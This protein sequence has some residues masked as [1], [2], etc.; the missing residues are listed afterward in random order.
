MMQTGIK[1]MDDNT[2]IERNTFARVE[3]YDLDIGSRVRLAIGD[4]VSNTNVGTNTYSKANSIRYQ[5]G[6]Q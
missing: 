4:A 1:V 5:Y 2:V 6:A 3:N